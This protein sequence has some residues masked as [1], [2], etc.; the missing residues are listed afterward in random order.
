MAVYYTS[1]AAAV[2]LGVR[3]QILLK[4]AADGSAT[5]IG[6]FL[7]SLTIIG[8]AIY[9]FA[10]L[11]YV[12]AL[13]NTV[14][15]AFPSASASYAIVAVPA[16]LLWNKPLGWSRIAGLLLIGSG[17]PITS[18]ERPHLCY[19]DLSGT[20][21]S[22]GLGDPSQLSRTSRHARRSEPEHDVS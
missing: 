5:F 18:I 7:N 16:Y 15:I 2:L 20:L 12:V 1:L 21:G 19:S 3:G 8:F 17:V 14:S 4:L 6:Q 11:C 9:I 13:K 10:A 22:V